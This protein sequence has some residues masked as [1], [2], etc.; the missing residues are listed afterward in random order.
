MIKIKNVSNAN[1]IINKKALHPGEFMDI[2]QD[3]AVFHHRLF[4]NGLIEKVQTIVKRI[5]KKELTDE[6]RNEYEQ[7]KNRLLPAFF[8]L[9]INQILNDQHLEDLKWFYKNVGPTSN[10]DISIK[11]LLDDTRDGEEFIE[12]L[13]NH[14]YPELLKKHFEQFKDE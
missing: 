1:I 14:I 10:T 2:T 9:H 4:E 3:D 7:L 5:E 13:L 12:V 11:S 6:Q 8:A